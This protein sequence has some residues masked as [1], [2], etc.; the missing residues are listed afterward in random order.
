MLTLALLGNDGGNMVRHRLADH[1]IT[2]HS[3]YIP[4]IQ[5]VQ[6]SIYHVWRLALDRLGR[7]ASAKIAG[8]QPH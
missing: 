1:A 5:E 8:L 7:Q 6:A 3:D 2:V 4:R